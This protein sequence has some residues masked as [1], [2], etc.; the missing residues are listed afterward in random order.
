MR[1]TAVFFFFSSPQ[2][3]VCELQ[4][5][6]EFMVSEVFD[7]LNMKGQI[8]QMPPGRTL[9]YYRD[10][11]NHL[12]TDQQVSPAHFSPIHLIDV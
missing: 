11:R 8:V 2:A 3:F 10:K 1:L 5:D 4:E 7:K 9:Q 6:Y 12:L